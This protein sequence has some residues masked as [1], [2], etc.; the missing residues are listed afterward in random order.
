MAKNP[1]DFSQV[2]TLMVVYHHKELNK[3]R[4]FLGLS[5]INVI[6]SMKEVR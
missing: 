3:I 6:L 2:L 5:G 4:F 1:L